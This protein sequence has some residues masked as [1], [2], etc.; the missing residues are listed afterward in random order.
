MAEG[1]RE[2]HLEPQPLDETEAAEIAEHTKQGQLAFIQAAISRTVQDEPLTR[3]AK[4]TYDKEY[5]LAQEPLRTRVGEYADDFAN[6]GL[7]IER[8]LKCISMLLA[9]ATS[10]QPPKQAFDL[11]RALARVPQ[12]LPASG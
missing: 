4:D 10:P 5:D 3:R 7:R 12:A 2:N 11:L 1:M 9:L 8:D 6:F